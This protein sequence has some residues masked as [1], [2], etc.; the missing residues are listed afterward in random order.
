MMPLMFVTIVEPTVAGGTH[1]HQVRGRNEFTV[2]CK[3][4]VKSREWA[5]MNFRMS[6]LVLEYSDLPHLAAELA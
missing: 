6:A 4:L 2:S 3:V 1:K 5:R